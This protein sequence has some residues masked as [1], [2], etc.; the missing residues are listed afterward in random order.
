MFLVQIVDADGNTRFVQIRAA[1]AADARSLAANLADLS[2]TERIQS[3]A[4]RQFFE[5]SGL[6]LPSNIPEIQ[7][8][9]RPNIGGGGEEVSTTTATTAPIN[10][11]VTPLTGNVQTPIATEEQSLF[12][13]FLRGL[14]DRGAGLSGV[15][16]QARVSRFQP[17]QAQFLAE[18]V[19]NPEQAGTPLS[20]SEFARTAPLAGAQQGQRATELFNQ[21]LGLSRGLTPTGSGFDALTET[22]QGF[23]N[24]ATSGQAQ[25][26][27][28]LARSSARQRFGVASE[29]FRPNVGLFEQFQSQARP[30]ALSFADFLN[31]KIF[32]G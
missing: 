23:L 24:P 18:Q 13:N 19:L 12:A 15:A 17:L 22:Q 26:L 25:T 11:D 20:F 9:V 8:P 28:D 32:G 10:T 1:T 7:R 21:A 16:G 30:T 5:A 4:S 6:Q 2:P 29:F 14:K 3:A 31:Q 27:E